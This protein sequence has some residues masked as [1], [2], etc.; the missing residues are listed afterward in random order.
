MSGAADLAYLAAALLFVAALKAMT[1]V[2]TL[3]RGAPLAAGGMLLAVLVALLVPRGPA[4]AEPAAITYLY[5]FAGLLV[6]AAGGAAAAAVV[7]VTA[8]GRLIA[9]FNGLTALAAALVALAALWTASPASPLYTRGFAAACGVT[10]L[11]GWAT[12]AGAATVVV[13]EA[14]L[15]GAGAPIVLPHHGGAVL[16]TLSGAI[17]LAVLLYV[18]PAQ[19]WLAAPLAV[20]AAAG[21]A[22]LA[23]PIRSADMPVAISML[24]GVAGL[25]AAGAGL[26]LANPGVV[27]GG[28]LAAASGIVLARRTCR[29]MNRSAAAVLW[30]AAG[31]GEGDAGTGVRRWTVEDAADVLGAASHIIIVPG[32]GL[33][34][35]RAQYA[36]KE[37]ADLLTARGARVQ[38]A[39]H[40]AAGRMPGHMSVILA[41]A[42]MDVERMA[43][44][45][46][47][48][49]DFAD[50]D[51]ALV[52]GA[53][54]VVNTAARTDRPAALHGLDILDA[55]RART[56]LI[57]NRS[58]GAGF[59]GVDNPLFQADNAAMILG[60]ARDVLVRINSALKRDEEGLTS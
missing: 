32:Y 56:V 47:V 58:D 33:A 46:A 45:A 44:L 30:G 37:L 43:D 52:I 49:G 41:E 5:V 21:G 18:L 9:I 22:L 1:S 14:K 19:R 6:G 48:N 53:N 51:V 12:A 38:V 2:R 17:L 11:L 28:A 60:D 20:A 27:I 50:A 3:R 34:V 24:T 16:G 57:V 13:R 59:S 23:G 35:A 8:M 26:A 7:K 10:T 25:A 55:G 31:G 39:I 15:L 29:A 40:P 36:V 4:A 42:D 54:D